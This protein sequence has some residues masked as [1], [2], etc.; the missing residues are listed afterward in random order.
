MFDYFDIHGTHIPVASIKDFRI[1]EVEYIFRPVFHEVRKTIF[2]PFSSNQIKKFEFLT[3]QPYAAIIGTQGQKSALGEYH[4]KDFKEALGK[5]VSGKLIY[6][7]ADKLK[8]KAFKQDRYQC[9]NLA[10]RA[11]TTYLDDVPVVLNWAD[12][13]VAEVFREDPLHEYLDVHT[14]PAINFIPALVIKADEVY[15]FYGNG[16]QIQDVSFEYDRLR[17][18]TDEYHAA[19]KTQKQIAPKT[20]VAL[21]QFPK[22]RLPGKAGASSNSVQPD[23]I[24]ES[25][26]SELAEIVTTPYT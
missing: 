11:F 8:L 5:D 2:S 26:E 9:L 6:T 24:V 23:E 19:Q 10:G 14:T 13:R 12:G 21:P 25:S 16:I 4:P 3:M 15:C 20:K 7:I 22:F 17:Q 18:V 1:I